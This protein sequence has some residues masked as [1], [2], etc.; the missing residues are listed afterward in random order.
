[1]TATKKIKNN[2][3]QTLRSKSIYAYTSLI[4]LFSITMSR[5]ASQSLNRHLL[6]NQM[7]F[8]QG[9]LSLSSDNKLKPQN[10]SI[11]ERS[12]CDRKFFSLI[13]ITH[14]VVSLRNKLFAS[15]VQL[16][17]AMVKDIFAVMIFI[18]SQSFQKASFTFTTSRSQQVHLDI[19]QL[20]EWVDANAVKIRT[21][22]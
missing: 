6:C 3:T 5:F 9:F 10:F 16:F 18:Y 12:L 17:K 1:M 8:L 21:E 14:V 22:Y 11:S 2:I 19:K 13:K 20:D 4:A 15:F 7:I